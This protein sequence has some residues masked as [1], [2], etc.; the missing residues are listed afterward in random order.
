MDCLLETSED[1][2]SKSKNFQQM[3]GWNEYHTIPC[4]VFLLLWVN[5]RPLYR[6]F[7]DLMKRSQAHFK[8]MCRYCTRRIAHAW[9][10][11]WGFL[12]AD[13]LAKKL[14]IKDTKS[15][16]SEIKS[17][18]L[19][20]TYIAS[21]IANSTRQENIDNMWQGLLNSTINPNIK[22]YVKCSI[23]NNLVHVS[24]VAVA[25]KEFKIR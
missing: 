16:C 11:I 6:P 19:N 2:P 10:M 20:S 4:K 24:D 1:L 7:F 9:A 18:N 12:H 5:S 14:L 25:V 15:F 13:T 3:P 23:S 8:L 21:T 22:S 17:I